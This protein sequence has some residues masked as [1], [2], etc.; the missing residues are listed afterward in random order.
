MLDLTIHGGTVLDGT[1]APRRRADVGVVDGKI[2]AIG[3][4]TSA[5]AARTLDATGLFVTPGFID[6]HSHSDFTV[7][8]D[9]RAQS[10]IVQGVTTEVIGNCGHGCAP[11]TDPDLFKGNIY[12]YT[13]ALEIDWSSTAEY[14]E[15]LEA[16]RPAVNLVPLVPNGNL[17]LA[18]VSDL[19]RAATPDEVRQ[20]GRLLEEG[21]EAGAFGYST[22]LEYPPERQCSEEEI[23]DLCRIVAKYGGLYAIHERNKEIYAVE[24]VEEGIREAEAAGVR[25]QVSHIIPRRGGP[26]DAR[27]RAI[28]AVERAHARGLDVGFDAHT[29]LHGI[30]NVAAALPPW[31]FDG[32][33]SQLAARLRDRGA[34][35]E[36]KR[37]QSIISSFGLGG[38]DRVYLFKSERCPDMVGKSFQELT[39]TGGDVYD[40]VFDILL[41]EIEDPSAPL[42]VCHSYEE[43]ELRLTFEHPLCTLESDATALGVDGPLAGTDFL[44][45]YTWAAWFLRR[46]VRETP[47]FTWE[48]AVH[49]LAAMP[50]ERVGL[51]DRG[52]IEV[53]A[54]ADIVALDP[55]GVREHG[56]L[57]APSQ[58]AEGV[59]HVVVNGGVTMEN[60]TLTG[61]R[62]GQVLRRS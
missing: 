41:A 32:G 58:L 25:L 34:R 50:A 26:A 40:A 13:P 39:P 6:I 59:A 9:P 24:A 60:G 42:C 51:G 14:F 48:E 46:F 19:E 56:T 8:V 7:L 3:D 61:D 53:G 23:V 22:G 36:M 28:A 55:E 12:G 57:E 43:E 29:R 5:E 27:E 21:L 10:S 47:V 62:S 2:E 45:A 15:R 44:G 11:I 16:A 33:L 52:R 18:V 30:T 54:R 37:H 4:L 17:R 20:M 49:K 31:A 1:G 38:W 35:E